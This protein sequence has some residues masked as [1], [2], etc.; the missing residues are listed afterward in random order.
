MKQPPE[1]NIT[2]ST[3]GNAVLVSTNLLNPGDSADISIIYE[4]GRAEP[5]SDRV[6][7]SA[8]ARVSGLKEV[9]VRDLTTVADDR[10]PT[11]TRWIGTFAGVLAGILASISVVA[12]FRMRA[13]QARSV[14]ARPSVKLPQSREDS[15]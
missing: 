10:E 14:R 15:G 7:I 11:A 12:Y 1:L 4:T 9:T 3:V 5:S 13:R 2:L 6:P 8:A